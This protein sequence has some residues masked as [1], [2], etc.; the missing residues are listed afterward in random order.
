MLFPLRRQRDGQ[1]PIHSPIALAQTSQ[2]IHNY[3]IHNSKFNEIG[4]TTKLLR[5]PGLQPRRK[6]TPLDP[7][8]HGL[9]LCRHT[10]TGCF[11]FFRGRRCVIATVLAV[12]Q[13]GLRPRKAAHYHAPLQNPP[14]SHQTEDQGHLAL[15][16]AKKVWEG[17]THPHPG[18]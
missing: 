9:R 10:S 2:T 7:G 6:F 5:G 11:Q 8:N 16:G 4:C 3:S 15:D 13:W 17:A 18:H 12:I 14:K 1:V